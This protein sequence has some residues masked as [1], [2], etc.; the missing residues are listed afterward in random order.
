MMIHNHPYSRLSVIGPLCLHTGSLQGSHRTLTELFVIV[1][2]QHFP[3][4]KHH[5]HLFYLGLFQIQSNVERSALPLFTL[6]FYGS[7]HSI[8]NV[9]G[10]GHSKTAAL[11]AVH[12]LVI[13]PAEGLKNFLLVL[14]RH[15]DPRILNLQVQAHMGIPLGQGLLIHG[16]TD[17]PPLRGEF[18]GVGQ[19]I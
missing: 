3:G 14:R 6:Q 9:F 15:A 11:R 16:N 4:R 13:L 12:T 19:D 18:H 10:N 7:S 17:A 5:I 8:H 2:H 1:H